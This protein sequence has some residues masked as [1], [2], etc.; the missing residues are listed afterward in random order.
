MFP[1]PSPPDT[2]VVRQLECV[3]C[4][5]KFAIAEDYPRANGA[6]GQFWRLPPDQPARTTLRYEADRQRRTV[7]PQPRSAPDA[8]P[9]IILNRERSK[10]SHLNCPRCGADNRNWLNLLLT[11]N[12]P[13]ANHDHQHGF[14]PSNVLAF[15][16]EQMRPVEKLLLTTVVFVLILMTL[17]LMTAFSTDLTIWV[18]AIGFLA[19]AALRRWRSDGYQLWQRRFPAAHFGIILAIFLAF[20]ASITAVSF[21]INTG[22]TLTLAFFVVFAPTSILFSLTEPWIAL[23]E[24]QHLRRV[25]TKAPHFERQ[26]WL[27]GFLAIVI[28]SAILPLLFFRLLPIGVATIG[29][30]LLQQAE[31]NITTAVETAGETGQ[32]VVDGT[33]PAYLTK[34]QEAID[35]AVASVGADTKL[36]AIWVIGVGLAS[37]TA[38]LSGMFALNQ[39]VADVDRQ[40]PPPI[41]HSLANMTRVTVWE[42]KQALEI[43]GDMG[44]VQWTRVSRNEDGGIHLV[45]VHITRTDAGQQKEKYIPA[46]EYAITADAWARIIKAKIKRTRVFF[47]GTPES[48]LSDAFFK[49]VLQPS[50]R[51]QNDKRD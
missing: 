34:R 44:H 21:E 1:L 8:E 23:R 39:F 24:N 18:V 37:V 28:F 11:E 31:Q 33:N 42:A 2:L 29:E 48:E 47:T 6:A 17:A 13:P 4:K 32:I 25:A 51:I 3:C 26:L 16:Q 15:W 19:F 10:R 45:G 30:S 50:L 38:V 5:E 9:E 35:N 12:A 7:I 20:L 41:F 40:I 22:K 14:Q 49:S 46:Q 36:M 27:R 43:T